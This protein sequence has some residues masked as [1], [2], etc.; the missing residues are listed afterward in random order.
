MENRL[1]RFRDRMRNKS[2]TEERIG[3][4]AWLICFYYFCMPLTFIT[5][6]PG[7]SVLKAA[8]LPVAGILFLRLFVAKNNEM[9]FNSVHLFYTLHLLFL[10]S[11]LLFFRGSESMTVVK[12]IALALVVTIMAT[13]RIYNQ[14]ERQ[15]VAYTWLL[16]GIV[17]MALCFSSNQT[18]YGDRTTI[19]V[20]GSEED[21]NFFCIYF[22][23]PVLFAMEQ[24]VQKTKLRF[25]APVYLALTFYAILRTGSR[26]GLA[27][28]VISMLAYIM[29]V[30]KNPK[31]KLKILIALLIVAFVIVFVVL[32]LLPDMLKERYS[33]E[34]IQEDKGSGRFDI[35][36]FLI[37]YVFS[38]AQA[39]VHGFGV[40]ATIEI[41][42][43]NGF[44]NTY[45]HNQWIQALF[46]QGLI[47]LLLYTSLMASSFFRNIKNNPLFSC[48]I[49]AIFAFSLSLS[50]YTHKQYLNV[51]M[52]CAMNFRPLMAQGPKTTSAPVDSTERSELPIDC[53]AV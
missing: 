30:V 42:T 3:V 45:A 10:A 46:D 53:K 32:P 25:I 50:F 21:P 52:M 9:R 4:D 41:M 44:L 47:G 48:A 31:T 26:G 7:M 43:E 35:W 16:V 17:C 36:G 15:L 33:L 24:L 2:S 49:V 39:L 22:I 12:D 6:I 8:T 5:L 11:T 18:I 37:N 14:K 19:I 38:D 13:C 20:M 27:A 29:L 34:Q 23:F 1:T 40:C 51:F 28:I